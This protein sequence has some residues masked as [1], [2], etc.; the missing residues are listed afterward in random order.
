MNEK[1]IEILVILKASSIKTDIGYPTSSIDPI[2]SDAPINS[3]A[4]TIENNRS[5]DLKAVNGFPEGQQSVD[6]V[7]LDENCARTNQS[8]VH[9]PA[10][11][12][13]NSQPAKSAINIDERNAMPEPN[14]QPAELLA[15]TTDT[16][17]IVPTT[18]SL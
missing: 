18:P 17:S 9:T 2:S 13:A 14:P 8:R 12:A 4:D 11:T 5:S 6:S 15:S 16:P 7:D 10:S 1:L 3:N